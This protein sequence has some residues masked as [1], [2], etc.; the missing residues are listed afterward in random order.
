ME[1]LRTGKTWELSTRWEER[2]SCA[3]QGYVLKLVS[4]SRLVKKWMRGT[5]VWGRG[6]KPRLPR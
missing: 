6:L 3:A 1:L 2:E 5:A 4:A